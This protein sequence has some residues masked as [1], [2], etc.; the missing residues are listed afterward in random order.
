MLYVII[1]HIKQ[2]IPS[3]CSAGDIH[4]LECSFKIFLPVPPKVLYLHTCVLSV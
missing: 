2:V 1:G 4:N 3:V